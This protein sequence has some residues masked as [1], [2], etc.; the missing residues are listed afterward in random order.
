MGSREELAHSNSFYVPK[1]MV[2][3]VM[4]ILPKISEVCEFMLHNNV[5][6]AFITE[7]WLQS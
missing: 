5:S 4:S 2:T 3:N 7:T 6:L 1:I